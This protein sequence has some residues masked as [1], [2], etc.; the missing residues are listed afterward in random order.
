MLAIS[1]DLYSRTGDEEPLVDAT[2]DRC[3]LKVLISLDVKVAR[4]HAVF[5]V[6]DGDVFTVGCCVSLT[7][8][9]A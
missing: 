5:R 7:P 6:L 4:V 8:E 3:G 9:K 2:V 1:S